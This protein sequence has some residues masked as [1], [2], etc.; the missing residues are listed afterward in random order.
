M[1]YFIRIALENGDVIHTETYETADAGGTVGIDRAAA[2]ARQVI[3]RKD[4]L[5]DFVNDVGQRVIVR[6][7]TINSVTVIER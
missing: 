1:R 3:S 7:R 5:T 4:G 2:R 6:T